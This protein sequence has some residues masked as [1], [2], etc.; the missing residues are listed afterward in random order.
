MLGLMLVVFLGLVTGLKWPVGLSLAA[1][2]VVIAAA[3]GHG[4]PLRHLVEGMFGYLDVSLVSHHGDGIY[5]GHREK[6]AAGRINQ[7]SDDE[8]RFFANNHACGYDAYHHVSRNDHRFLH[9]VGA[10]DRSA[11]DSSHAKNEHAQGNRRSDCGDGF[12]IRYDCTTGQ[13]RHHDHRRRN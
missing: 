13:Y 1:T 3:D 4:L 7:R 9:R 2:S 12:R 6:R 10:F 5:E 8:I 11:H